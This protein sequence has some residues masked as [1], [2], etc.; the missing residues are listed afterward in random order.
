MASHIVRLKSLPYNFCELSRKPRAQ[1]SRKTKLLPIF[2]HD[3]L[4]ANKAAAIWHCILPGWHL[5]LPPLLR[6]FCGCCK[7][8]TWFSFHTWQPKLWF[9][10]TAATQSHVFFSVRLQFAFPFP[11][12]L[13]CVL[14]FVT[15]ATEN[16]FPLWIWVGKCLLAPQFATI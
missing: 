8:A 1:A 5:T 14:F 10:V 15:N 7:V 4:F 16:L 9:S 12:P 2:L 11:L 6:I 3:F 13:R